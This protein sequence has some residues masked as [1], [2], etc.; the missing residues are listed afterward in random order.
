VQ[1]KPLRQADRVS[2]SPIRYDWDEDQVSFA[3][4]MKHGDPS[5][6]KETIKVDDSNKWAISIAQEMKSLEKNQI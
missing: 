3:L 1:S 6:Y 5:S 4:V 2:V